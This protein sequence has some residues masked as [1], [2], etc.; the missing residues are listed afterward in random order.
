VI[1]NLFFIIFFIV[2]MKFKSIY[3]TLAVAFMAA[4]F[5]GNSTGPVNNGNGDRSG[6]SGTTC[7]SCHTGGGTGTTDVIVRDTFGAVQ[8]EYTPGNMYIIDVNATLPT[9][10]PSNFRYG[11]NA[12][13]RSG[14]ADAGTISLFPS[15]NVRLINNV[16]EHLSPITNTGISFR[17]IAP[18]TGVGTVQI[19][20]A[21]L[22][23]NMDGTD[24]SDITQ[25]PVVFSFPQATT[26]IAVSEQMV[27]LDNIVLFPTQAQQVVNLR[28]TAQEAMQY[29]IDV[30]AIS[31]AT[32]S[33]QIFQAQ[34]GEQVQTIDVQQL[35]AGT[36]FVRLHNGKGTLKAMPF[37]KF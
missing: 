17:W 26:P 9:P 31:G 12:R 37:I 8:T 10:P 1:F 7:N 24:N 13:I 35:P 14:S 27:G 16:V 30:V 29:T 22:A 6:A 25:T 2:T 34:T 19:Y 11:F 4:I 3:S 18:A 15:T 21:S 5:M 20:A 23:A 36:Y 33:T 28:L 32:V